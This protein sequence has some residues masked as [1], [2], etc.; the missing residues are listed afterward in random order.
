MTGIT[1]SRRFLSRAKECSI[2]RPGTIVQEDK[3]P[4]HAHHAQQAV[5]SRY[6]IQRLLWPGNSP[7]LNAIEAC[8]PYMKRATTRRGAPK[9]RAE[10]VRVW[11]QEWD[12]LPQ[13]KIQEWIERIPRHIQEVIRLEGG[14]EYRE[15]REH[16]KQHH[17]H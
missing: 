7:D 9:S 10:A 17:K 14:N 12:N 1:T 8:W 16:L 3:A 6:E 2:E 11:E 4:A 5:Y 15:G 13:E